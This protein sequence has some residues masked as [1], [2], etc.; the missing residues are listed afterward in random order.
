MKNEK[1]MNNFYNIGRFNHPNRI[2]YMMK[3]IRDLRPLTMEE[4]KLWYLEN[5]HDRNYLHQLAVE[6]HATIPTTNNVSVND[7]EE[8][9]YDVMFRR[10]FQGYNKEKQALKILRTAINPSVEESPKEWDSKYFIDFYLRDANGALIG[11]QLKPDTFYR[12][13]YQ[14]VVDIE[15]KMKDFRDKYN[16]TTFV[17]RYN[18]QSDNKTIKLVN[19]EIISEIKLLLP[20]LTPNPIAC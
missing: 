6:M 15:G 17:L 20:D 10:T 12:G 9:I 13:N 5:V 1:A 2:G 7:C 19:P 16:A 8:Y 14:T 3:M 18:P 4:W 11:I